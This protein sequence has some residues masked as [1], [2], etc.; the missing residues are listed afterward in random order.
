LC[1]AFEMDAKI[2]SASNK[3]HLQNINLDFVDEADK[4]T[5]A[6]GGLSD[7]PEDCADLDLTGRMFFRF[8]SALKPVEALILVLD[9]TDMFIVKPVVKNM[10]ENRGTVLCGISLRNII[11]A[12]ADGS[13]LHVAVRNSDA[14]FLIK[15]GNMAL[16]FESPGTCLIVK[17]YLDRSRE[18]L[19]QNLLT[20]IPD[21]LQAPKVSS[22]GSCIC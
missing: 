3:K 19:R 9:P 10:E 22:D 15:N 21:L 2:S 16:Q 18:V 1:L 5:K 20:K 17:Q 12:S 11:G 7:K 6:I 14:G 8:Q 13:W 4:L